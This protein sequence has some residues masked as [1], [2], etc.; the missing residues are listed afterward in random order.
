MC[1]IN[2]LFK[3]LDNI[4]YVV[5]CVFNETVVISG[6]SVP[7][8]KEPIENVDPDTVLDVDSASKLHILFGGTKVVQHT[9]PGKASSGLRGNLL[10]ANLKFFLHE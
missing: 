9:P 8:M 10:K 2:T 5:R 1:C 3:W 7:Q 6:E 4:V